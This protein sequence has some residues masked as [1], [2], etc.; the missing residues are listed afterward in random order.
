LETWSEG[1]DLR[2][3]HDLDIGQSGDAV[4]QIT[5]HAGLEAPAARQLAPRGRSPRVVV[6][7]LGR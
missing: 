3:K 1:D 4:D 5:P 7:V 2:L 6:V